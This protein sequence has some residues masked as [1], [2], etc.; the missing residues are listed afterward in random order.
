MSHFRLSAQL[1]LFG[2]V[3]VSAMLVHMGMVW[4]LVERFAQPPLRANVFGF[5]VAFGV[6][7]LGHGRLTFKGHG[8]DVGA[9]LPR[10]FLVASLG[11]AVNQSAYALL[12]ARF[13][14]QSYLPLL[15]LVLIGVALLTFVLS[16]TWAFSA[17]R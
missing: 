7:Y 3:G 13:G 10:F 4:L 17:P 16:R 2:V 14:P 15:A 12:L 1:V 11:F 5:L 8:A 6:S 9:S